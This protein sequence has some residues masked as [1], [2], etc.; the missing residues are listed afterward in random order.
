[1]LKVQ[2]ITPKR[3]SAINSE[4]SIDEIII[5]MVEWVIDH[6]VLVDP[7]IS[8]ISV[9]QIIHGAGMHWKEG[10]CPEYLQSGILKHC[11]I[12]PARKI[13]RMRWKR[14]TN[15]EPPPLPPDLY[16]TIKNVVKNKVIN[17]IIRE[18]KYAGIKP[19]WAQGYI[20]P[21]TDP[22]SFD[23]RYARD[24]VGWFFYR[25]GI[26]FIGGIENYFM[27]L[28]KRDKYVLFQWLYNCSAFPKMIRTQIASATAKLD[29]LEE[30]EKYSS[31]K[32]ISVEVDPSQ[33]TWI[34]NED[35][36]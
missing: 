5:D 33:I 30:I 36:A 21:K 32:K 1:M 7:F 31:Y 6:E 19:F 28:N 16:R 4:M 22:P 27:T 12:W 29:L 9:E 34:E 35:A 25:D 14:Y 26:E 23:S 2:K 10:N 17:A 24:V 8:W 20:N 15:W 13:E 3:E 11:K 18:E